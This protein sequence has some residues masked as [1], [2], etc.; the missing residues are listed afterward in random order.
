M[1]NPVADTFISET[2]SNKNFGAMAFFNAGTT[3][4]FTTNRGLVRFD[5]AGSIPPGSKILATTLIVEVTGQPDEPWKTSNF[6]L[7]RLLRNWGEGNNNAGA[8]KFAGNA[9]TNE[10]NWSHRF[11]FTAETWGQ[12]GGEAGLDYVAA[13]VAT[14][15]VYEAGNPYS[16]G[17]AAPMAADVQLWLDRPGTNFGWMLILQ[18][19]TTDFTARRFGSRESGL[20]AVLEVVFERPPPISGVQLVGSWINLSYFSP[21]GRVI[22]VQQCDDLLTGDWQPSAEA[23]PFTNIVQVVVQDLAIGG[24][25]FYRLKVK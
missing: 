13:P 6:G 4:E 16:F 11:A 25:R 15:F 17:P 23:G 10:A 1:L 19:E 21:T 12:A 18:N 22:Q 2:W 24:Q 9:G 5:I 7:H 20:P 8:P 14:T 3:Q